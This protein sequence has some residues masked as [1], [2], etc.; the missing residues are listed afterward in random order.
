MDGGKRGQGDVVWSWGDICFGHSVIHL[1]AYM[2]GWGGGGGNYCGFDLCFYF[3]VIL[4]LAC[5][6]GWGEG[7][8]HG[9]GRPVVLSLNVKCS[10]CIRVQLSQGHMPLDLAVG[11]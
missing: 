9:C 1:S 2:T 6:M 4:L 3:S 11:P 10:A 8:S 7:G 5:N